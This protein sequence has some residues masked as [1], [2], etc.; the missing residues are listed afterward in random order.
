MSVIE[1]S[2]FMRFEQ[3][4]NQKTENERQTFVNPSIKAR[5]KVLVMR[6]LLFILFP[7]FFIEKFYAVG[8]SKGQVWT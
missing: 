4:M 5:K 7:F 8:L 6:F 2:I 3:L 1:K